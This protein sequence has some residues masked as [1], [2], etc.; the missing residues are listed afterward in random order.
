MPETSSS[1]RGKVVLLTGA[2]GPMGRI[3]VDEFLDAGAKLALGVRRMANLPQLELSLADRGESPMIIP[4]DLRYEENVVR[5]VHR[6]VQRF[7]RIDAI[8]NAAVVLGPRLPIIDYPADPWR[9]VIST[10]VTGAYLLCR[11]ALPWMVRQRSGSIVHITTP[12]TTHVKPEWG[13]YLVGNHAV[14]GLTRLLAAELKGTGVRVN[15]VDVGMM[16]PELKPAGLST[17]W[18]RTI[19]H[20]VSDDSAGQSGER[21]TAHA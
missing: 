17:A 4:C 2:T 11:E 9:D 1:V 14:E 10:N 19:L 7:G 3:L 6:V 13:A 21:I 15:V 8:V 5:I 20:L 16:T 18:A 12:L